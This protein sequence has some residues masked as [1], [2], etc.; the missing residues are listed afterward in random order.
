V[1][2]TLVD[3]RPNTM[4][5]RLDADALKIAPGPRGR[6]RRRYATPRRTEIVEFLSD[7]DLLPAIVFIFSRAG[8]DEAAGSLLDAGVRLTTGPERDRIREIARSHTAGLNPGDL[9][10]LGYDRWLHALECGI[11][12]HHAGMVPPFKEAVEACFVAGLVKVVFATET[13]A[14]GINMPARS[15]VIEALSKF[16]GDHH[17]NLTA[18]EY[19][20]L[21]GRA[22]RRGIDDIGRAVVLWSPFTP[23]D[24]VA[25]LAMSREFVLESSFRPTYN[26]TANLVRRYDREGAHRLLNQSFAQ[27]QAD[28]SIV[29]LETRRARRQARIAELRPDTVCERGSVD[30]YYAL[31]RA[32]SGDRRRAAD[33]AAVARA[34]ARLRPGDVVVVEQRRLAV[35]SVANRGGDRVRLQ[36]LDAK[37]RVRTMGGEDFEQPPERTATIELPKPYNPG[38]H[39]FQSEAA[40]A[41]Q[42][43]RV[44]P[45]KIPK[46]QAGAR[47][48]AADHPV[49]RCPDRDAHLRAVTQVDRLEREVADLDRRIGSSAGSVA[50]RF[51]AVLGLLDDWSF[52]DGWSLT[53]KGRLLV[54]TYHESDL[55]IAEAMSRGLFD[56]L[57]AASLA[58]LVS[59]LTY[60]HR[61]RLPPPPAW[62]PSADVRA[63]FD[64]LERIGRDLQAAERRAQLPETRLPDPTFVPLAQAWAAGTDLVDVLDDEDL[65]GGDFVRNIR[66]LLDLLRQISEV[67]PVD[68]TRV[69]AAEATN[70]LFRGVIAASSVL[71]STDDPDPDAVEVASP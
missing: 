56:G 54:R 35:L 21:T 6:A 19:T 64:A 44:V 39:R 37:G 38:N 40:K 18:G 43:A 32:E 27:F 9:A 26:M 50:R 61:S 30:E 67:A 7:G 1:L 10:V 14:L 24:Q 62:F 68:S 51:D 5:E 15:V 42:R 57:D 47:A 53:A 52:L 48:L 60:E 45:P 46:K 3:G 65:S 28:R 63:R 58:A 49:A 41:L 71:G 31:V 8:C 17:E 16:T 12:A 55:V 33:R 13:L 22:G 69:A 29:Q 70:A 59:C 2:P 34:A 20:Q 23:F 66:Q 25:A 4:G 11:A 36:L